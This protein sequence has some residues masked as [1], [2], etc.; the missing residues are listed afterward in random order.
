LRAFS[1]APSFRRADAPGFRGIRGI[2]ANPRVHPM[3]ADTI[4]TRSELPSD[5][6]RVEALQRAAFGPGA[7]ARAAFRV[8]E[9]A[10]HDRALSFLTELNGALVGSVRITPIDVGDA[11]GL[12]LGPLVVDPPYKGLGYGKALMRRAVAAAAGAGWPFILLVG[13]QPYYAPFGFKPLP[14]GRVKMPGPVDPARFLAAEL[15]PGAVAALSG[16]VR[17]VRAK[18]V[19]D[20]SRG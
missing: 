14:P 17:G 1:S 9:Q 3:T 13:D 6:P 7:Y 12:L 15:Q 10:P 4:T 19:S 5:D 16:T 18:E 11:C 20:G 2:L 8:R